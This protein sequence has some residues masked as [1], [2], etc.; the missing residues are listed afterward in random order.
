MSSE[1]A[2]KKKGKKIAANELSEEDQKKVTGG[3]NPQPMP[4]S[5]SAI[6]RRARGPIQ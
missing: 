2:D 6:S 1:S 4:P 5:P 3:L